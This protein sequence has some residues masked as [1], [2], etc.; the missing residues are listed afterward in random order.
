MPIPPCI[1]IASSA[2]SLPILPHEYFAE[3]AVTFIEWA[4]KVKET[5]PLN[6]L[7]ITILVETETSRRFRF[8]AQGS[9]MELA[10]DKLSSIV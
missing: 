2:E 8:K 6:H 10:L 7:M 3:D 5:L 4:D 1:W 9:S